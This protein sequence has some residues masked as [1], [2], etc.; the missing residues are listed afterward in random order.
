MLNL[1]VQRRQVENGALQRPQQPANAGAEA[2]IGADDSD[3]GDPALDHLQGA[4]CRARQHV[5]AGVD[6]AI[7]HIAGAQRSRTGLQRALGGWSPTGGE[8]LAQLLGAVDAAALD[9]WQH[10]RRTPSLPLGLGGL[11]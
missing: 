7:G 5:H 6:V 11:R 3:L 1:P 2:G 9:R 10:R 4:R 8:D